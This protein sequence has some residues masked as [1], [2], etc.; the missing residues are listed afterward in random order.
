MKKNFIRRGIWRFRECILIKLILYNGEDY[1]MYI[2]DNICYA[3]EIQEN[4]KI[5][6]TKY[7]GRGIVIVTFSTGEER[8]FDLTELKE[9]VY[10]PLEDEEIAKNIVLFNGIITWL[11]GTIY[12]APE[13]VYHMSYEYNSKA[14]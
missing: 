1:V 13:T 2:K 9:P 7:I 10:K 5:Q 12:I 3:G 14:I 8:L 11:D 4:I 6:S